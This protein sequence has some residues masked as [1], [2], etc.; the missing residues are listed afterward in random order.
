MQS[1]RGT[2]REPLWRLK[3][4]L[5][6]S[7]EGKMRFAP[8]AQTVH[9]DVLQ[10][11]RLN[12]CVRRQTTFP[13]Y[14]AAVTTQ[15]SGISCACASKNCEAQSRHPAFQIIE[16][17]V[18]SRCRAGLTELFFPPLCPLYRRANRDVNYPSSFPSV[19][20]DLMLLMFPICA[21][22]NILT[23]TRFAEMWFASHLKPPQKCA[24]YPVSSKSHSTW[25]LLPSGLPKINRDTIWNVSKNGLRLA[26]STRFAV[27]DTHYHDK[28]MYVGLLKERKKKKKFPSSCVF[29]A[30]IWC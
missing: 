11:I 18:L 22:G 23:E 4:L 2:L 27:R 21:A 16:V 20:A 26:A 15:V 3:C 24:G 10:V 7:L 17:M 1:S 9:T 28:S 13:R 30:T 29:A 14:V 12:P 25:F 6:S 8:S 5:Q 19:L